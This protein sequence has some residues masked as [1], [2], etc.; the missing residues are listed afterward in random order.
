MKNKIKIIQAGLLTSLALRCVRVCM[1]LVGALM[2][3]RVDWWMEALTGL[4]D[5]RIDWWMDG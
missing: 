5:S 1:S 3:G 4:V 2:D